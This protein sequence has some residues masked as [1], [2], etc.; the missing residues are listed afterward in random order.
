M[1]GLK[2]FGSE[3]LSRNLCPMA[4]WCSIGVPQSIRV[5]M[6]N[7]FDC[8]EDGPVVEFRGNDGAP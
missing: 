4:T 5:G 6:K 1:G 2:C 8:V 7:V 3:A